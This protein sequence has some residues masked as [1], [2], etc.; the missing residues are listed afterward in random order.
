MNKFFFAFHEIWASI[1]EI[2]YCLL[3]FY[4]KIGN[5]VFVCCYLLFFLSLYNL[6]I[7]LGTYY[8]NELIAK[9]KDERISFTTDIINGI[10]SIKFLS[11]EKIFKR[12]LE[13]IRKKEF[14]NYFK[15]NIIYSFVDMFWEILPYL[16]IFFS[17]KQYVEEGNSIIDANIFTVIEHKILISI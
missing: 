4:Y 10:K 12:K 2:I 9:A 13:T 14:N 7:T 5:A 3:L 17:L 16:I 11:W 15:F 1:L 8:L 6:V